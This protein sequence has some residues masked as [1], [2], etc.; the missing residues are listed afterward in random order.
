LDAQLYELL[1]VANSHT[2]LFGKY[3]ASRKYKR[4]GA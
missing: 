4:Q 1:D 3:I 2:L